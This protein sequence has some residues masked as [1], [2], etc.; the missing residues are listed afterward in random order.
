M[1]AVVHPDPDGFSATV[2]AGVSLGTPLS[3]SRP[4]ARRPL[5]DR[6]VLCGILYVL[7]AGIQWEYLPQDLGFGSGMTCR[8]RD[9]EQEMEHTVPEPVVPEPSELS[10]VGLAPKACQAK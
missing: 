9:A 6:Q 1:V 2:L 8:R 10:S 5:P 4:Q 7:H 3:S